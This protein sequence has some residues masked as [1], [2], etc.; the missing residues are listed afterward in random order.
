LYPGN[1]RIDITVP[2]L[3]KTLFEEKGAFS[4]M[5]ENSAI[6]TERLIMRQINLEL[7][8]MQDYLKWMRDTK[9]N[10]FI[11]SARPTYSMDELLE[12]VN[13]KNS[14]E[15]VLLFGIFLRSSGIL[16]GTIKLEPIDRNTCEAWLGVLIGNADLRHLGYGSESIK[17]IL[18]YSKDMLRLKKIYLGVDLSN[19][20]AINAY[21]K[22]GFSIEIRK[23][24]QITMLIRL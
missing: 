4:H 6:S 21:L 7:D 1:N 20:V 13:Q 15:D 10:P 8:S 19:T 9:S 23:E 11:V 14:H 16:I 5:N 17:G 2:E 18:R 12:Y 24:N 3:T 22:I